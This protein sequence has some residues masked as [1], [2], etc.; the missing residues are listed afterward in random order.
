M[1]EQYDKKTFII[2]FIPFTIIAIISIS[3]YSTNFFKGGEIMAIIL[4][5]YSFTTLICYLKFFKP[6]PKKEILNTKTIVSSSTPLIKE[7]K[8]VV[9]QYVVEIDN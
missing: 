9:V 8:F 5:V 6:K 2:I 7:K 1:F 4:F 3:L